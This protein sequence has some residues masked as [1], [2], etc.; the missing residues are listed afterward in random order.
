MV[1]KIQARSKHKAQITG[2]ALYLKI[3]S[4]AP[5]YQVSQI[6]SEQVIWSEESCCQVKSLT[7]S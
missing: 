4:N 5:W 6:L 3:K 7:A 1:D 2:V